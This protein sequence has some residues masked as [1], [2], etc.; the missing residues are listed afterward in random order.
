MSRL[1][2]ST[3]QTACDRQAGNKGIKDHSQ[4]DKV[5]PV[6]KGG[7]KAIFTTKRYQTAIHFLMRNL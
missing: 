3:C 5:I 7:L 4:V 6:T 2:R 1:L